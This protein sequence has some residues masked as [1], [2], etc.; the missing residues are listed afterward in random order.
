MHRCIDNVPVTAYVSFSG[1][2]LYLTASFILQ[3][4]LASQ[5]PVGHS[6]FDDFGSHSGYRAKELQDCGILVLKLNMLRLAGC[7]CV[8]LVW[9]LPL[10]AEQE[11]LFAK[12]EVQVNIFLPC[13]QQCMTCIMAQGYTHLLLSHCTFAFPV[14]VSAA[15]P[16]RCYLALV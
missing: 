8:P 2:R 9:L 4:E 6:V 14:N 5:V 3:I 11:K 7:S 15:S 10:N 13:S 1:L 12:S 16:Q